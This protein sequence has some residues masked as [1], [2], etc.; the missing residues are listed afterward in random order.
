[1]AQQFLRNTVAQQKH[2]KEQTLKERDPRDEEQRAKSKS[3]SVA[4]SQQPSKPK[5][6]KKAKPPK[7]SR[8]TTPD[9][10]KI[11]YIVG[12]FQIL[13]RWLFH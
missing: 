6:H 1:M 12:G 4:Q 2:L 9:G 7:P 13:R 10:T 8:P 11:N 3:T 5:E